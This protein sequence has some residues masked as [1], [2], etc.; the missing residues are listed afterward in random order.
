MASNPFPGGAVGSGKGPSK[1]ADK[2]KAAADKAKAPKATKAAAPKKE[3]TPQESGEG[4]IV[5]A[6]STVPTEGTAICEFDGKEYPLKSFATIKNKE[7]GLYERGTITRKNLPLYRAARKA[8]REAA[9]AAA[10][11]ERALRAKA[12]DA[13]IAEK[14]K[15]K[16]VAAAS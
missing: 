14:A 3:A 2:P 13:K 8:E 6:K 9:K 1:A 5:R 10:D 4:Q 7:T 16:E 15:D 12:R 11:A